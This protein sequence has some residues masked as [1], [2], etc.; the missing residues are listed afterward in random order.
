MT[1]IKRR[2][3]ALLFFD[4]DEK[5]SNPVQVYTLHFSLNPVKA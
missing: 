4:P 1:V 3:V 5:K 2:A